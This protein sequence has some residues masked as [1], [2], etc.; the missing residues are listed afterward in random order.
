MSLPA[1]VQ[2]MLEDWYE[3]ELER[4]LMLGYEEMIAE[5]IAEDNLCARLD[6]L[7]V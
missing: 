6:A 2:S 4:L 3:E 7:Q 5:S 1:Q